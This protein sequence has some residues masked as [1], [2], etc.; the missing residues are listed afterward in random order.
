MSRKPVI[1]LIPLV[2]EK[3]DSIWMVPGYMEGIQKAGGL[4]VILPLHGTKEEYEQLDQGIDGYLLTGG[5]D[6][7]PALYGEEK[8]EVCGV[9]CP[10]RDAMEP[11]I[12]Q[13]AVEKDKPLLAICRGIQFMN[14]MEGGTLYQDLV[15]ERQSKTSHQMKPPYDRAFHQVQ[16]I[17]GTPLYEALGKEQIGVNS[18]HHQAIRT[19]GAKTEVMAVAEDGLIEGI[20]RPDK[21]FIW[22]IQWHPEFSYKKE[23]DQQRIFKVFVDA[24]KLTKN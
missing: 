2:D 20:Y 3:L 5:H 24:I 12:Y 15:T 17:K 10:E 22:G 9:L 6:I 18:Y 16:I 4:P 23:E 13:M 11:Y 7:D 14:A 21:T 1:G 19:C 8:K